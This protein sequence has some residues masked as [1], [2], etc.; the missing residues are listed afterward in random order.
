M[1]IFERYKEEV[2]QKYLQLHPNVNPARVRQ[3]VE[4]LVDSQAKDIPCVMHN[5]MTREL[6]ETSVSNVF[7]WIEDRQPIIAGNATFFKQH[8]EYLPPIISMLETLQADRKRVKKEMWKFDKHSIDY[9]NRNTTQMSIKVIMNADYGGSGTPLSPFYSVYIPPAT[10]QTA[11]NIT[12][13][14]I[15]CLEFSTGNNH[16]YAK[17]SSI[18]ELFDMI[19]IVIGN[20]EDRD[21]IKDHF[22]PDVVADRLLTKLANPTLDDIN[23]VHNYCRTL[24]ND[25]LTRLMLAF[26]IHYVCENYLR[27][28]FTRVSDYLKRHP[29][30]FE[31]LMKM[32]QEAAK[33]ELKRDGFGTETPETIEEDMKK[34]NHTIL[35]NCIY[36]F[37]LND[38][39]TRAEEMQRLIVCV[40]DTDSLM[41]HFPHYIDAFQARVPNFKRSCLIAS[42]IGMRLFIENIIPRFVYYV[43]LGYNIKDEY[44][45]KKFV[46]KNEFTFLAM[47]LFKKKMY[48]SSM[49]VQEGTPRDIHDIAVTGLSFKKRDSAEFLEPIM[50]ELYDKYILTSE[51]INIEGLLDAYYALRERL[52]VEARSNTAYYKALSIKTPEAY[53]KSKSLPAQMKGAIIWNNLY[54]EEEILPMDRVLLVPLNTE[55]MLNSTDLRIQKILEISKV[56]DEKLK[57]NIHICLPESYKETPEWL[58]PY[59]DMEVLVDK[60]LG[61]FKQILGL[62]DVTMADTRGGFL[63]ARMLY[64]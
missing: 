45:R 47:S 32:D 49:F 37:I 57:K 11:K 59:V 10:T 14:L 41:V 2:F 39:E 25:D 36:P 38:V 43:T 31:D 13:T 17:C 20:E 34:I 56:D 16:P 7:N 44:Y 35:D 53:A 18:N 23:L 64:I 6:L 24:A 8:S 3:L 22:A 19:N 42:A 46:F 63:A 1:T 12:T 27:A 61:P 58:Q 52:F 55:L 5:N 62:F 30:P 50:L 48:A 29:V 60:L 21:I 33:A 28:E 26:N 54:P 15:C 40:T 9:I 4:E 51:E